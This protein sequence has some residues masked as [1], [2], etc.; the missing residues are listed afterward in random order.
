MITKVFELG[1][2]VT[3]VLPATRKIT[4]SPEALFDTELRT[5]YD[6]ELLGIRTKIDVCAPPIEP[7]SSS[8]ADQIASEE[9]KL[10]LAQKIEEPIVEDSREN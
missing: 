9:K 2:I 4:A 5:T 10:K 7:V 1:G 8:I 6:L 3:P